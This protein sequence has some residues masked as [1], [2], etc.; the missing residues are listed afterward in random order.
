[1]D[2]RINLFDTDH[3]FGR[4]GVLFRTVCRFE[5]E[6]HRLFRDIIHHGHA[7]YYHPASVCDLCMP[8]LWQQDA[9]VSGSRYNGC[10]FL[11]RLRGVPYLLEEQRSNRLPLINQTKN[12]NKAWLDNRR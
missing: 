3:R 5:N 6:D 7:R 2:T 10:D 9:E 8:A 12:P 1:M 11:L 4:I